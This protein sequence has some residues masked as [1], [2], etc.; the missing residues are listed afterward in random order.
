[1]KYF[2]N[3][4]LS[5]LLL[6]LGNTL[7]ASNEK[8]IR[9]AEA[10][11]VPIK[12][13]AFIKNG[14][15]QDWLIFSGDPL[16]TLLG[17]Y[18]NPSKS[19][20]LTIFNPKTKEAFRIPRT[21]E[22]F[23]GKS[24]GPRVLDSFRFPG[25]ATPYL[26]VDPNS[27]ET[28]I[29]LMKAS[30][31][32]G[33]Y[34]TFLGLPPGPKVDKFIAQKDATLKLAGLSPALGEAERISSNDLTDAFNEAISD[35][36]SALGH[37]LEGLRKNDKKSVFY[38]YLSYDKQMQTQIDL[39]EDLSKNKDKYKE[40]Y[41]ASTRAKARSELAKNQELKTQL[42]LH[43]KENGIPE[44]SFDQEIYRSA[45]FNRKDG[46]QNLTIREGAQQIVDNCTD[47]MSNFSGNPFAKSFLEDLKYS[48]SIAG[49][50]SS[51]G[52]AKAR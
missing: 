7:Y 6:L 28:P 30:E 31:V 24:G 29:K 13:I 44:Y 40:S 42:V 5:V 19:T 34:H 1:M 33:V 51:A 18:L 32:E 36:L 49:K 37:S 35:K 15:S 4:T 38:L 11:G 26:I 10:V 8:E 16:E 50:D 48:L 17:G 39:L 2:L 27:G 43:R 12:K 14:A 9:C 52:T 20:D 47:I 22:T 3:S 41:I 46:S 23:Q 45:R 25:D 21:Q